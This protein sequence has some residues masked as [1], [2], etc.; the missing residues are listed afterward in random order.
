MLPYKTI[1]KIFLWIVFILSGFACETNPTGIHPSDKLL[2]VEDV[3]VTDVS[4]KVTLS[5]VVVQPL[6]LYRNGQ[7]LLSFPRR[8][9]DTTI[10]DRSLRPNHNYT[11]ALSNSSAFGIIIEVNKV[12]ITTLDT[13]NHNMIWYV[14]TIAGGWLNDVAIINDS[15]IYAVGD[16]TTR[17][18]L[19][20]LDTVPQNIAI[21]NGR[22]WNVSLVFVQIPVTPPYPPGYCK[23]S[24]DGVWPFS[25][26]DIWLTA[27]TDIIR[28]NGT[29]VTNYSYAP[30]AVQRIW[31]NSES[32]VYG[33]WF[34][35][36]T[37]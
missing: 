25:S 23:C 12:S 35:L 10:I 31:A 17:D 2:Q 9:V 24:L 27:N 32:N 21:W 20:Q 14:D 7:S 26:N 5:S 6:T 15:L 34:P 36:H 1:K 16:M 30:A 11:Y 18:S 19:S 13:T 37:D 4:L 33:S 8:P 22:K 3:E 28:W 29:S